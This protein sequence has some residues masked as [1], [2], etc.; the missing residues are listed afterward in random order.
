MYSEFC[1]IYFRTDIFVYWLNLLQQSYVSKLQQEKKRYICLLLILGLN[2]YHDLKSLQ[3]QTKNSL[4][5]EVRM[6]LVNLTKYALA[7]LIQLPNASQE[8]A[9]SRG[10]WP[11][12]ASKLLLGC[13]RSLNFLRVLCSTGTSRTG[14]QQVLF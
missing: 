8:V 5:A 11:R 7:A 1:D 2:R 13:R 14:S 4:T 10:H 6:L 3:Q 12:E 9:R